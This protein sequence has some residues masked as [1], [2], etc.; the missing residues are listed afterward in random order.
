[1]QSIAQFI[2][3]FGNSFKSKNSNFYLSK[4]ILNYQEIF[5][6]CKGKV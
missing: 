3:S 2:H 6:A 4:I 5:L 1:M